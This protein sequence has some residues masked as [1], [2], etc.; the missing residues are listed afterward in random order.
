MITFHTCMFYACTYRL[1]LFGCDRDQMV[2]VVGFTT[3]Y[4]CICNQC[5]SPLLLWVWIP[6]R[7][8][9]FNT[10]LCDKVCQ[11]LVVGQ[12]FSPPIKL[13]AMHI[14]YNWNIVESDIKHHNSNPLTLFTMVFIFIFYFR[15][16]QEFR[17]R[18]PK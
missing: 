11:W 2:L 8:G 16:M 13:T 14:W 4:I 12:W 5:L 9:V 7:G 1:I 15:N 17:I 3:T 18:V 6:L 10:T